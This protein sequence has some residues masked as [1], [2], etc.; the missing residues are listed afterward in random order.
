MWRYFHFSL[1]FSEID[2]RMTKRSIAV[3][4]ETVRESC[5]QFDEVDAKRTRARSARPRRGVASA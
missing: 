2:E 1:R 5:S 4:D 3:T